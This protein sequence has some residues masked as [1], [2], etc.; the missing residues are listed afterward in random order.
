MS[1]FRQENNFRELG[2]YKTKDGRTVKKGLLYRSAALGSMNE[3]ELKA[4][5]KMGIRSILDFRSR[6]EEAAF[7]DPPVPGATNY[8]IS[9]MR[10]NDGNDVDYSPSAIL[11]AAAKEPGFN[12]VAALTRHAYSFIVFDSE[13]YQKMFELMLNEKTPLLFHCTQGKDR[14]GAAAILILLALG[15]DEETI[16]DD[17]VLTNKYR[18]LLIDKAMKK[19]RILTKISKNAHTFM[20]IR[21]GVDRSFGEAAIRSIKERYPDYETF[22]RKEYALFKACGFKNML[23][24]LPVR[25]SGSVPTWKYLFREP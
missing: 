3:R 8:H 9:A 5:E 25:A 24:P 2:G 21:E 10:D 22:F 17:Y 18:R 20:L 16:L 23:V 14:T 1:G 11:L 12:K 4:L 13:A 7:P 15:V 6:L 19:H